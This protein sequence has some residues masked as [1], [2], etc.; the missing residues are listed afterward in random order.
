MVK[1]LFKN[2]VYPV[3]T[4]AGSII[5]VGIFSLPYI[6]SKSGIWLTLIYLVVLTAIVVLLNS[7]VGEIALKTP[8]F[9]RIPGFI[10]FHLGKYAKAV[11]LTTAILGG[12]GVLLV[13]LI[14]AS[15]FLF[16]AAQPM[17]GGSYLLYVF[18][19]SAVALFFIYF[20]IKAISKFELGAVLLLIFTMAIIFIKGFSQ[21]KFSNLFVLDF[22]ATAGS[23][24]GGTNFFL[25]YG[26]IIFSLWGVGLI[27]EVEEMLRKRKND[28]KK[29]I[30][31]SVFI[32]AIIYFLFIFLIL[33]IT[34]DN[35][36]ESALIGL[37]NIFK[38][39]ML[40]FVLFAGAMVALNAF[41]SLGLVLKKVFAYDIGVKKSQAIIFVCATPLILFLL[42]MRS[43]LP[44]ISFIG[45]VFIGID[46]ILILLMYKKIKGKNFIF[47]PLALVFLFGIIYEI[48]YFI[49]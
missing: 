46:G 7:I 48:I 49:K 47:Y 21:I 17:F 41:I 12:F 8:D 26:P 14:I 32:P 44:I 38:G 16:N 22:P 3:A 20:D 24:F 25:P 34:G 2:Y 30:I 19:F 29:I 1:N 9:K 28:F 18:I 23:R 40:N 13:Y 35:T 36:T 37:K 5:G 10:G 11:S 6:A 31:T 45:G 15:T 43:F 42:G 27:P 33:S 39:W 4:L